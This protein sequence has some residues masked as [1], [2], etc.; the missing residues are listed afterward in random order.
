MGLKVLF[1][2]SE[3]APLV[4]VNGVADTVGSLS[5]AL[6]ELG[7]EVAIA[8]PEYK[9]LSGVETLPDTD[10]PVFL[11]G[12][13]EYFAGSEKPYWNMEDDPRRFAYF[14]REV[15]RRLPVWGFNPDVLHL[16]DWY[17]S[18]VSAL[19]RKSKLPYASVLTIHNLAAQGVSTVENL[20]P[21]G[22]SESDLRS[23]EWDFRDRSIDL[24]LQG[25]VH[26]DVINTVSPTYAKEILMPEFGEGLHDILRLREGRLSGILNGIDYSSY[27]PSSDRD[28]F[29]TFGLD[30]F[31]EGKAANKEALQRELDLPVDE[32][33]LL[34]GFVAHLTNQEGLSLVVE[35]FEEMMNM[36]L[37]FIILGDG[38][39]CYENQLKRFS[40]K[41]SNKFCIQFEFDE[42]LARKIYAASDLFLIPS[43]FEPCGFTQMVAMRYGSLPLVRAAGGLND[44]VVDGQ[45]GFVFDKYEVGQ[46]LIALRRALKVFKTPVWAR[47]VRSA[48]QKDFSWARSAEKYMELYEKAVGYANQAGGQ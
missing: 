39:P 26:A 18:W 5:R 40:S 12:S 48:M 23:L 13:E 36:P 38:D 8:L 45:D 9:G 21:V 2:A 37:Q 44:S 11:V 43:R 42:A 6:R 30:N 41:Y 22:F 10:I 4:R 3:C 27:D 1:V 32:R 46:M 14:S 7:V 47:M 20:L 17:A 25:V 15:V 19:I 29:R 24:L 33:A 16:H 28:I 34:I 31:E 35:G